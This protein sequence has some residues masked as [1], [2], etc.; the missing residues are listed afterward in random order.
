MSFRAAVSSCAP[1]THYRCLSAGLY[2]ACSLDGM[3][4]SGFATIIAHVAL[5]RR[6]ASSREHRRSHRH[7]DVGDWTQ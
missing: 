2:R 6:P 5:R 4:C 3:G 7:A 1:A